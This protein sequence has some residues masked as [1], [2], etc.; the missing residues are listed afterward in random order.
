MIEEK[1]L[2]KV[3]ASCGTA[4]CWYGEFMCD[5]SASAGTKKKTVAELR[6]DPIESEHYWSAD[7]MAAIYG[8]PTPFGF[9]K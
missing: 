9:A 4:S 3:C 8:D 1:K 5:G 7:K 6:S 2:I